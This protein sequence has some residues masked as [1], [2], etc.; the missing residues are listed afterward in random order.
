[1]EIAILFGLIILNGLFAMSEIALVT[2]KRAR[3]QKLVDA[4]ASGA[5]AALELGED[6]TRFLSTVQIG[7]TSISI[8]NGIVGEAVL[9]APLSH[10]LQSLSLSREVSDLAATAL[11]VVVITYFSIVLGELLPKRIGQI[12]P[13]PIARRVA[14]PML[15]MA[16]VAKPFV[17]LLSASTR[18][19]LKLLGIREREG[20]S[21]TEED[22]EAIL[23]EGSQ[24]GAIE[25]HEHHMVRNV[26]RLDDRLITSLMVPRAAIVY[27][28]VEE[29][30]ET[31]L[32]KLRV[33]KHSRYPVCRGGLDDVLGF[34]HARE[35]LA[36]ALSSE[37]IELH[38]GFDPVAYVPETLTGS[39]LLRN[40]KATNT[41]AALVIDEYGELQG[42]VTLQ[43]VLEAITGEFT[44][45]REEDGWMMERD[46]GSLLIDGLVPLPE[47]SDRLRIAP[48]EESR[49]RYNTLG[50]MITVLL[51][52][53]P[54]TGDKV[55]WSGWRFEVVDMDNRRIDK[56]LAYSLSKAE[57]AAPSR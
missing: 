34:A 20:A 44:P 25:S 56:V 8:L 3:L 38:S 9:A 55:E 24:S 48:P 50:G 52:R 32:E 47:L 49:G 35:L 5:A 7:I 39:E 13:E 14:K 41:H 51:G 18:V 4:G 17:K 26:F 28:D 21:V 42:M 45:H 19:L 6:P 40:F 16:L 11:V 27:L 1:M 31:M 12:A 57:G 23:T 29:P 33:A 37:P 10:W 30:R 22:I 36:Q 15:V 46:D 54:R 53:L 43:D 2:A